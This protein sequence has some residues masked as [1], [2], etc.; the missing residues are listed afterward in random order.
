MSKVESGG[1][2]THD[3]N[4]SRNE[5]YHVEYLED[6]IQIYMESDE[7]CDIDELNPEAVL[8]DIYRVARGKYGIQKAVKL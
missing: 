3:G 1:D 6:F 8:A 7:D 5:A 2:G 4:Y